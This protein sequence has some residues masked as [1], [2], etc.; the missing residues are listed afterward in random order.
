MGEADKKDD[1]KLTKKESLVLWFVIG[2][3][4]ACCVTGI[5]DNIAGVRAHNA[6]RAF[7]EE[8]KDKLPQKTTS[9]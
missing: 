7:M 9:I 1:T 5:V 8:A 6:E 3:F 4:T 2:I